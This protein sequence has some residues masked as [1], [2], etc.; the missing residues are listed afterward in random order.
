MAAAEFGGVYTPVIRSSYV[1]FFRTC[2]SSS[3]NGAGDFWCSGLRHKITQEPQKG[4]S[5]GT[6]PPD[7]GYGVCPFLT[8]SFPSK[9]LLIMQHLL[10]SEM[11]MRLPLNLNAC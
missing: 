3:Q 7:V 1:C 8:F 6:K 9:L 4:D 5:S 11:H 2:T 10:P